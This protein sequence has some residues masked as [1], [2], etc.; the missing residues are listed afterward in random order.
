MSSSS[1]YKDSAVPN[2][3]WGWMVVFGVAWTNVSLAKM[4][5]FRAF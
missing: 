1:P 2:G 4:L 3:R 5:D